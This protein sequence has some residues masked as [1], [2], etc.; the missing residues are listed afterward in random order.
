MYAIRSYYAD[1]QRRV[2]A[3]GGG[4]GGEHRAV[5]VAVG[6]QPALVELGVR[7]VVERS[8][9]GAGR[10]GPGHLGGQAG[11]ARVLGVD[12]PAGFETERDADV[13]WC[14]GAEVGGGGDEADLRVIGAHEIGCAC[15]GNR[16]REE[17]A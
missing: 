2:F 17:R 5:G 6:G 11:V 10:Q 14:A 1:R 12:V 8:D 13:E 7:R 9:R 16:K 3:G 4:A 15:G